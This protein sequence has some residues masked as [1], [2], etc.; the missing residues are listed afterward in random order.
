MENKPVNFSLIQ[1]GD[2]SHVERIL[3]FGGDEIALKLA[4]RHVG[5]KDVTLGQLY[6]ASLKIAIHHLQGLLDRMPKS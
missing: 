2:T 4:I 6:E 3:K 1:D 5:G